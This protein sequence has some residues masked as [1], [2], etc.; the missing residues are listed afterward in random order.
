SRMIQLVS[1]RQ[2][3]P[4]GLGHAVLCAARVAA[5]SPI[6]IML[7]DDLIDGPRPGVAQL[8]EVFQKTG[9]GTIGLIEG[10]P[11]PERQYR[12]GKVRRL[13]PRLWQLE[14]LVEKPEP[15]QAPSRLAIV[16]RYVL[17]PSIF[18]L[19]EKTPPGKGGEIQLTDG[20]VALA[21]EEGLLGWEF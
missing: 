14:D 13:A 2:K 3:E 17:P 9:K 19:L 20:L 7:P 10:A 12:I 6:A 8:A 21:R 1:I 15:A 18:G 16:A 11:G 5:G 4:L